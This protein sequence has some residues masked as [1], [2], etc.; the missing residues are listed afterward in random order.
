ML[1]SVMWR[2]CIMMIPHHGEV[3]LVKKPS[4]KAYVRPLW[5]KA[6][7]KPIKVCTKATNAISPNSSVPKDERYQDLLR[8]RQLVAAID[9]GPTGQTRHQGVHALLCAHVNQIV[10]IE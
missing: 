9:L 2:H 6:S 1:G 8:N 3:H 5:G 10:L 7:S 4:D